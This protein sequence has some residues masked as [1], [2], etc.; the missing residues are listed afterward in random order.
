MDLRSGGGGQPTVKGRHR[1]TQILRDLFGRNATGEKLSSG[2]HLAF[3]HLAIATTD[4]ALPSCGLQACPG[5]LHNEFPFHLRHAGHDMEEKSTR[6]RRGVDLVREALEMD[7]LGLEVRHQ[8]HQALHATPQAVELPD[9]QGILLAEMGERLLQPRAVIS[10]SAHPV[11][12]YALTPG[13][14]EGM[15]LEVEV[16]VFGGDEDL[17]D[18]HGNPS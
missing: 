3:G 10:G 14:A 4:A 6:R 16:L 9:H 8:I 1:H 13:L 7:A 17:A 18:P 5:P 15:G 2:L 11:G 12:E